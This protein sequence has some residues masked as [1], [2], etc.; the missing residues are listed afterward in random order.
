MKKSRWT[1][2]VLVIVRE[3]VGVPVWGG[4]AQGGGA[5][6][7]EVLREGLQHPGQRHADQVQPQAQAIH[8]QLLLGI[9][10][11]LIL[12]NDKLLIVFFIS[13]IDFIDN[14]AMATDVKEQWN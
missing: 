5:E 13:W 9:R 12:E 10:N 11:T 1:D 3:W 7:G 2:L 4:G 14:L 8:V 6:A